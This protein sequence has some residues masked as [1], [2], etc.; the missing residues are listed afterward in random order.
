[1]KKKR[2]SLIVLLILL[3]LVLS[4]C[5]EKEA[6]VPDHEH[7]DF[8]W[9][10]EFELEEGSYLFHFGE[11]EDETMDVA[12]VLMGDNISDLDHHVAHVITSDKE[13]LEEASS[14]VAKPDHAYT[15]KM[16]PDH[17]HFEFTIEEAGVYAI[18]TEH[19]PWESEQQILDAEG[20][21]LIPIKEHEIDHDHDH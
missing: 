21:E 15:F 5:G 18:A 7:G 19:E 3:S 12:F 16:E 2:L 11:T 9:L 6:E 20:S 1:M 13:I 17:G 8:E 14:F 4:A 10:A